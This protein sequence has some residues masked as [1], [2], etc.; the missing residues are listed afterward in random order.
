VPDKRPVVASVDDRRKPW[1][2][3]PPEEMFDIEE[4]A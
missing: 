2:G 1:E 3:K 4:E